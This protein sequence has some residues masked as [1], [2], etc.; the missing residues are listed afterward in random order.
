MLVLCGPGTVELK[1]SSTQHKRSK[2]WSCR[3]QYSKEQLNVFIFYF[4]GYCC[5]YHLRL[6]PAWQPRSVD[7]VC[8]DTTGSPLPKALDQ[9]FIIL[10]GVSRCSKHITPV[11]IQMTR[12][13][14]IMPGSCHIFKICGYYDDHF[15]VWLVE[16]PITFSG[17][18]R[19]EVRL[20]V[21]L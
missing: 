15:T 9:K 3:S 13:V 16:G 7:L 20:L 10:I 4:S 19:P 12:F 6:S 1:W 2:M 11:N 8:Q 18:L 5:R 21:A 17:G 14:V